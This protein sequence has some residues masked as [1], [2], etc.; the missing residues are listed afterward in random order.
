MPTIQ[1]RTD[2]LECLS[3]TLGW[4]ITTH[5]SRHEQKD[6]NAVSW[7]WFDKYTIRQSRARLVEIKVA[8]DN[9]RAQHFKPNTVGPK[10]K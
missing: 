3:E 1:L 8:L 9:A 4:I 2:Q 5:D 7:P 6:Y 10:A